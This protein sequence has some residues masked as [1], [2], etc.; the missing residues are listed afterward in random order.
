MGDVTPPARSRGWAPPLMIGAL[1]RLLYLWLTEGA[2]G[3]G[4]SRTLLAYDWVVHGGRLFGQTTWPELNYLL[5]AIGVWLGGDLYWMPRVIFALLS[6]AAIP[7]AWHVA[8]ELADERAARFAAWAMALLPYIVVYSTGGARSDG[9]NGVGTLLAIY[10][11][12]RWNFARGSFGYLGV[13]A[14]GVA[15]A[16][17][18]RFDGVLT[19]AALGGVLL[20]ELLCRWSAPHRLRRIGG[21]TIF[22]TLALLYPCL[23]ALSW[24]SQFG[25]PLHFLHTAQESSRQFLA[26]G[27]HRRWP[28]WIYRSYAVAFLPVATAFILTPA[29]F[30]L[31]VVGIVRLARSWR[32][33]GAIAILLLYAVFIAR[34]ILSFTQ[35]PQ[36]RYALSGAMLLLP[37]L[38]PGFDVTRAVL[39]R[40]LG[41]RAQ[42]VLATLVILGIVVSQA[43]AG[44]ATVANHG[45]LSRHLG[46]SGLVQP[47]PRPAARAYELAEAQ[48]A[49]GDS[50]LIEPFAASA[51]TALSNEFRDGGLPTETL[52]IF[53]D[54]TYVRTWAEYL[55]HLDARLP[56]FRFVLTGADGVPEGFQD[57]LHADPLMDAYQASGSNRFSW[58]D[59]AFEVAGQFGRII[60]LRRV[61]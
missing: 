58:R 17:G 28:M 32:A 6:L 1:A 44:W 37:F 20:A 24:S 50:L 49:A 2:A 30:L 16:E 48:A 42:P 23:L 18:F 55:D 39:G 33:A 51:Y 11:F 43:L 8:R 10:G 27:M 56:H 61:S 12:L 13:A 38:G 47:A 53:R 59:H 5:P 9:A 19:G 45:L 34:N 40:R 54:A 29:I 41:A 35:Q 25:D 60:L 4:A 14:G 26:E 36:I 22:G 21:M 31:G 46:G 57:G 7:L 15:I 3:D 52:T